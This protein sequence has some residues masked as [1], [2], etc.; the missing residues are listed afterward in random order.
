MTV[1]NLI[2]LIAIA[3]LVVVSV[4]IFLNV[5]RLPNIKTEEDIIEILKRGDRL[6]AIKA[7]RQLYGCSLG[8]AKQFLDRQIITEPKGENHEQ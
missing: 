5:R 3:A 6:T 4:T 8:A 7:Y 1:L 2:L